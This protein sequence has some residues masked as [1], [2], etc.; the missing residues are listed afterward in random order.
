MG[1][2]TVTERVLKNR[3]KKQ[4]LKRRWRFF[5]SIFFII[6]LAIGSFILLKSSIF[7]ITTIKVEGN[8]TLRGEEI[9]KLS[10]IGVGEN[11]FKIKLEE[12]E[13]RI[14]LS[15]LVKKVSLQRKYPSVV[16][17]KITEREPIGIIPVVEGFAKIDEEGYLLAFTDKLTG[18][19]LPII[20]GLKLNEQSLGSKV[21]GKGL[22]TAVTFLKVMPKGVVNEVSEINVANPHQA[23][24]YTI[25][26][27]QIRL[28]S[29]EKIEE[30]V[31]ML[32]TV[33]RT[34]PTAEIEYI[35]ISYDGPPVFKPKSL[36]SNINE[37][38]EVSKTLN[39]PYN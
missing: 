39:N 1:V 38:T 9:K 26:S 22:K 32:E 27:T 28:G 12:A 31:R 17:V 6:I 5:Q 14:K 20:T 35:D 19:K 34:N 13:K 33:I 16:I 7:N 4:Q 3:R 2:V 18:S 8:Q 21:L 36:D 11:I 23:I 30:K 24:V 25:T 29:P 10:G 15:P 37:E